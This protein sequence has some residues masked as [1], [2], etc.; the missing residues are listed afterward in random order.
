M[1]HINL[2][3]EGKRPTAVRKK[4]DL[5]ERLSGENTAGILL[6]VAI[7]PGLLFTGWEFWSLRADLK[8]KT[9]YAGD[10]QRQY[11]SLKSI[12]AEV[13][14]FKKKK[15]E[16][17]NKIRVIEDLK[18]NQ[19]GP[20]QVMEQV[21]RS[22]PELVWLDRMEVNRNTIRLV[23][24]GQNENAIANFIDNLDKVEGFDEPAIRAMR[25]VG[26]GIYNY[27]M[28]VTYTLKPP[29]GVG[30]GEASEV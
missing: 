13:E 6:L 3:S 1:I 18:N 28:T 17:E 27:D 21:S 5:S 2:I 30:V 24:R 9:A 16:L 23:G 12:I 8:E 14:D 29:E 19:R 22:L 20:V 26:G 25:A 7:L 11:D 10:L 4:K 15:Q